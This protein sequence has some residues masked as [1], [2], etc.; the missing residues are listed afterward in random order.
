MMSFWLLVF[1]SLSYYWR[2]NLLMALGVALTSAILS[3]ALVVGDSVRESLRRN[4]AARLSKI[5]SA[6]TGGERFFTES[7]ASRIDSRAVPVLQVEGTV[8]IQGGSKRSNQVQI[9]GVNSRF[10]ALSFSGKRPGDF[11]GN[12][13]LAINDVLARRL[14]L[15]LEDTLICRV[16]IPGELS[17]DAPLSGESEQTE[18]F[19][20]KVKAIVGADQ[21]GRYSLRAE[22]VPRGTV[23]LS[24][25]RLQEIL[26]KPGRV[27][28]LLAPAEV[29]ESLPVKAG[30][31]WTLADAALSIQEGTAGDAT[32]YSRMTSA[33]VF[34]DAKTS[35]IAVEEAGNAASAALTYLANRIECGGKL[36]PYSM[37]TGAEPGPASPVPADLKES[38]IVLSKWLAEDLGASAG[39]TVSISY[40][41]VG[42]GRKLEEKSASFKVH[43]IGAIG[44]KGWDR[45]WTPEFPGIFEVDDLDEW[46]PGIPIDQSLIR[47]KDE[48]F[49]DNHRATPKAFLTLA[50]ARELF[51]NRFG[52]AT[53]I[54]FAGLEPSGYE[55]KLKERL[56]LGDIGLTIR[57]LGEEAS[58]AVENS[59]DFGVL[60]ASMS[61]FLIL[62]ALVLTALLFVFGVEHRANQIGLLLAAGFSGG[63]ARR[64]F[65]AEAFL[66]T[67]GGALVGLLFG[68]VYTKLALRGMSGVWQDAAAGIDFVYH[69][70]PET[71]A[72]AFF[73]TVGLAMVVVWLASRA[74]TRVQPSQL[75]ASGMSPSSSGRLRSGGF[76]GTIW[77]W[78]LIVFLLAGIGCLIAPKTE[79]GMAEQGLFFGAGFCLTLAGVCGC[80]LWLRRLENSASPVRD[81]STLGRQNAVRRKGRS[82]AVAGLMAAGVFMV[83]AINSF[84]LEGERGAARRD[85][86]T[87][88]FSYAG[89]SNLPIYEDL[90][91]PEGREKYGLDNFPED[92]FT[93]IP[94]RVSDGDDAS[95]LNLNRA[96]RPRLMGVDPELLKRAGSPF[97]FSKN[98][99]VKEYLAWDSLSLPIEA[100]PAVLDMNTAAYAL[101]VK[102]GDR[103]AY[104]NAQGNEFQVEVAALLKT[105]ILQGNLIISEENFIRQ[106]PNSGGYRFFLLDCANQD[107]SEEIAAHLTRM[108]RG[109]GLEMRPAADRLN[110]FNA[111]QNTYLS[112]F[113]TLG[114]LGVLLGTVGLGIVAGRNVM[115]RKGQ[116]GLLQAIGFDR[117][118]LTGMILSEHW[119]LHVLGVVIG[120][121]AALVAVAPKLAQRAS[122]LPWPLLIGVNAAILVGGLVFCWL[123]ARVALQGKLI[124]SLRSE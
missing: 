26:E 22:Q 73:G 59:L 3:G 53:S 12:G 68:W 54:R 65:L 61:F 124:D 87:G 57:P 27:N 48:D 33:R 43:S 112:I 75:I 34:I 74:V 5:D 118:S 24:L 86:G 95:C 94:F 90:N 82:L 46:E 108:F 89:E 111:V 78:G 11:S 45:S 21:M 1:R 38:E 4:A 97:S 102:P 116:L 92:A 69:F 49:W 13:G 56:S 28:L 123:A 104:E 122:D 17:K 103:I 91:S 37:I 88:G 117:R 35:K 30:E 50:A 40:Y 10:W 7:L 32:G 62:A 96:Q 25:S 98:P 100:L 31:Q 66:L 79:G 121:G 113:S 105:S 83:T 29:S 72:M 2:I 67:I 20:G 71:L 101:R 120:A 80:A 63:K 36:N 14:D 64:L 77:F 8:S 51:V 41:V 16:E 84:R 115:E 107:Q 93:V 60:F 47:D 76:A 99:K 81:L 58:A 114:G 85:S 119:F 6:L 19:N 18:P 39:D 9:L 42:T 52:D 23:F 44:E 55:K 106:F 110:E 109:R 70:R 15:G